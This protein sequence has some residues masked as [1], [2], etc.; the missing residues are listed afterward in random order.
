MKSFRQAVHEKKIY[1]IFTPFAPSGPPMGATPFSFANL[2]QLSME[3]FCANFGWNPSSSSWEK[4]ENVK[5]TMYPFFAPWRGLKRVQEL[6][7]ANFSSPSLRDAL[8][9]IWMKSAYTEF[10]AVFSAP[11]W[12]CFSPKFIFIWNLEDLALMTLLFKHEVIWTSGS[13]EEDFLWF[14]K[15]LTPFAP[16][17]A[18][19]GGNALFLRNLEAAS[20]K[21]ALC[22]VW[23]KSILWFLRSWKYEEI[24]CITLLPP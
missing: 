3:I 13:W 2:K 16:S 12:G 15:F 9:Q 1:P 7:Y 4:I 10:S 8:Y 18:P 17:S 22:Q 19:Y 6:F 11:W 20:H 24:Q 5:N 23:L 14:T 21:N